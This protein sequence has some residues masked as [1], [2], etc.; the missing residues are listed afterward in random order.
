[1]YPFQ[2]E[3]EKEIENLI[4]FPNEKMKVSKIIIKFQ[5]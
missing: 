5:I 1:M 4:Y 2:Y 3:V